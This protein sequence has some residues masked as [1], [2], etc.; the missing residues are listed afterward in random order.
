[1]PDRL[2]FAGGGTGGH[3][4]PAI[5]IADEV[6]RMAPEAEILFIGTKG[7]IESQVVP[8]RGYR[9][10][11]IWISGFSRSLS[12]STVLFPVKVVVSMMQ[13]FV[14]LLTKKPDVVVGT[15][16]YVCGP[17][18]MA[19]SLLGIPTLIQ[20]Q[21]SYPGVTTRLLANR[22]NQVHITFESTRRFLGRSDNV[23]LTG[24]PVRALVGTIARAD[25]A[26]SLGLDPARATV[27]VAGG[28]QGAAS[29][30]TAMLPIVPLLLGQG[31]QVVWLTGERE[32]ARVHRQCGTPSLP[33]GL[34]IRPFL[35]EMEHAFA[36]ADLAVCRSGAST[37]AELMCAGLPSI[38]VPYPQAA[39]DHQTENARAMVEQGAALLCPD[40]DMG[41]RLGVMIHELLGDAARRAAMGAAARVMGKPDAARILANAALTLARLKT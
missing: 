19:A 1:M 31:V 33:C 7:R 6:R 29:I 32:F 12:L 11:S 10:V 36:A 25:G 18:V 23:Q 37:L 9:F 4:F 30:N 27:L 41:A 22:V 5:A 13:S 34:V 3:L 17:P 35:A 2:F 21:N 8:G 39:A 26:A 14:L 20:E 15:G 40:R 28:S 16:G 38:L 24:N